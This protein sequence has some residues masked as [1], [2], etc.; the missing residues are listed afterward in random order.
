M[1]DAR[2]VSKQF[3]RVQALAGVRVP[4]KK[5]DTLPVIGL[6]HLPSAAAAH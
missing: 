5:G 3:G 1:L 4:S 6:G 2:G